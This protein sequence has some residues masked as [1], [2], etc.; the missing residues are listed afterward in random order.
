MAKAR[1]VLAEREQIGVGMAQASD[2]ATH[3]PRK[4]DFCLSIAPAHTNMI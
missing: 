2:L 4:G 1:P 3:I